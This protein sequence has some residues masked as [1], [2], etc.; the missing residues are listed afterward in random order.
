M[1]ETAIWLCMLAVPRQ[2][3][4]SHTMPTLALSDS[5]FK[6]K[7]RASTPCLDITTIVSLKSMP[8]VSRHGPLRMY[9]TSSCHAAIPPSRS[10]D[11]SFHRSIIGWTSL[12]M[13]F[14]LLESL[15][16]SGSR[17]NMSR[18]FGL[19]DHRFGSIPHLVPDISFVQSQ[20]DASLL[21]CARRHFQNE[22]S[23]LTDLISQ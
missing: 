14:P 4:L 12:N 13:D 5:P 19:S 8:T 2:A 9:N 11:H 6:P 7:A 22:R 1:A 15:N 21:S 23:V 18:G 10:E 20:P 3:G 16:A 17:C